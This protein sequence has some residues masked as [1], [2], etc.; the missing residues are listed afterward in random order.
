MV[1]L[2]VE[3]MEIQC[4]VGEGVVKTEEHKELRC[5]DLLLHQWR[6][7]TRM[8]CIR[9]QGTRITHLKDQ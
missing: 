1:V 7:G 8:N 4:E 2:E 3:S 5:F 9:I 6:K